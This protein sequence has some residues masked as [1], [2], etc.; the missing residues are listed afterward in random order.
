LHS[1]SALANGRVFTWGKAEECGLGLG[2]KD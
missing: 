1:T 2:E